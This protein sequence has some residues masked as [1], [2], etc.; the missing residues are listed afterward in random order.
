MGWV[1]SLAASPS[2]PTIYATVR[3]TPMIVSLKSPLS[4]L[5]EQIK[6]NVTLIVIDSCDL[7]IFPNAT[8]T[9]YIRNFGIF[10]I[11]DPVAAVGEAHHT[12]RPGG[13]A[14]LT[15]WN[16]NGALDLIHRVQRHL[17][18]EA[19]LWWPQEAEWNRGWTLRDVLVAGGFKEEAVR[20]IEEEEWTGPEDEEG[21]MNSF[22]EDYWEDANKATVS[23]GERE[24]WK[25][26]V[27]ECLS[28]GEKESG[29]VRMVAWIAVA[30]KAPD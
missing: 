3:S 16:I 6:G 14:A 1:A 17:R 22:S 27:R 15:M 19:A 4:P 21:L 29:G 2:L 18:P 7:F 25:N 12:L 26:A 30:T 24:K 9:H 5:E 28:E 8:F 10:Y 13:T 23:G 20:M 11:L